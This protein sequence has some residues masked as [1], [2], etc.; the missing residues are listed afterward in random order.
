[1]AE[2][3]AVTV[4][5]E[6]LSNS[7]V[8]F[9]TLEDAFGPSSLGVL[10]VRDLPSQYLDLRRRVLSYASHLANLPPHILDSLS[11]PE[12]NFL[13]GWS[14]GKEALKNGE[15]DT[16]KG[17]FYVNCDFYRKDSKDSNLVCSEYPELAT[18]N[19]WPPEDLLPGFRQCFEELCTLIIDTAV[20][21]ARQ[22]D[23]YALAKIEGYEPGYLERVVRSSTTT[24]ARLLHYFPLQSDRQETQ[25]APEKGLV[26][27]EEET[28]WNGM[29]VV[30]NT[31]AVFTQPGLDE[32]VD[33]ST[34]KTYAQFSR[35]VSERFK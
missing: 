29:Q 21:V 2:V 1:M 35:E 34:G 31:L 3:E 14:H 32:I 5:A 9:H 15:Y 22:C 12:A 6:E 18:S 13:T 7:S 33:R 4:S 20:M 26:R 17:S 16:L 24:K 11:L 25:Q 10:I 27:T 30:R 28:I 19:V 23:R 8:P